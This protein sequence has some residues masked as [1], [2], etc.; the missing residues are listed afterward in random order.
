M[1]F[2]F[3]KCNA[4]YM[5]LCLLISIVLVL[6]GCGKVV[7]TSPPPK[8]TTEKTPSKVTPT[9][10]PSRVSFQI[11]NL[12]YVYGSVAVGCKPTF[13]FS[14]RSLA[15]ATDRLTYDQAEIKQISA[16]IDSQ[17]F[18]D[19]DIGPIDG[20]PIPKSLEYITGSASL[21]SVWGSSTPKEER[22]FTLCG[23]TLEV[24]NVSKETLQIP[25]VNLHYVSSAGPNTQL[26]RLINV[27][28]V[29]IRTQKICPPAIGGPTGNYGVGFTIGMGPANTTYSDKPTQIVN[30]KFESRNFLTII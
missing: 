25:Q 5:R 19:K 12:L 3:H 17:G 9:P 16:F 15:L 13:A 7:G 1:L 6:S 26:Y 20:P 8:P 28:S 30:F 4:L 29:G 24:T 14:T 18:I 22:D 23:T 2:R 21:M 11:E 10:D 27:C